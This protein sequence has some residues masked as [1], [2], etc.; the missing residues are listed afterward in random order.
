[1]PKHKTWVTAVAELKAAAGSVILIVIEAVHALASVT[2]T[3]LVPMFKEVI[4]EV[5]ALVDHKYVYGVVPPE[6]VT[7]AAPVLPPKHKTLLIMVAVLKA[8]AGWVNVA[9]A[10]KVQALASVMVTVLA[11][12]FKPVITEV[13]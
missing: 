9:T 3:V 1:M 11:A 2:V 4:T 6:A 5:V 8:T 10:V 7:V 13:V 12:A